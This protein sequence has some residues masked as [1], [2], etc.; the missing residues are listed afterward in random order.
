M[1]PDPLGDP[2]PEVTWYKGEKKV[3]P[4]RSD[5]RVRTD[6][7]LNDDTYFLEIKDATESDA[8]EYT[9]IASSDT[10]TTH[11]VIPVKVREHGA[12]SP[13]EES[14]SEEEVT[15]TEAAPKSKAA[16][17]KV[18]EVVAGK[19]AVTNEP[20][21]Q[22]APQPTAVRPGDTIQLSCKIAGQVVE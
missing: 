20:M 16:A 3:K 12:I 17:E 6:W 18:Q 15:A 5:K 21:I 4:R 2:E 1:T 11:V 7:D 14:V 10:G 22:I 9:C 8:G 13:E 19:A